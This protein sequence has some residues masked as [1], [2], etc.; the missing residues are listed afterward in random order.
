MAKVTRFWTPLL[1]LVIILFVLSCGC[2]VAQDC[3]G[4][5]GGSSFSSA[6]DY[7]GDD[8]SQASA[9]TIAGPDEVTRP[10]NPANPTYYA[11][12][13]GLG[14]YGWEVAGSGTFIDQETGQLTLGAAACGSFTVTVTD[15]CGTTASKTGRAAGDDPN[16][17]AG[18][19]SSSPETF[20]VVHATEVCGS[21]SS[22]YCYLDAFYAGGYYYYV[23]TYSG[24]RRI[25]TRCINGM[26]TNWCYMGVGQYSDTQ[27]ISLVIEHTADCSTACGGITTV[28]TFNNEY[29]EFSFVTYYGVPVDE[30]IA[31]WTCY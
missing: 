1:I 27:A 2:S 24:S 17:T 29:P 12:S 19:W 5:M 8:C 23:T 20:C 16:N 31:V 21:C 15:F 13:G 11:A 3:G 4:G 22:G 6:G 18:V 26:T 9:L 14:P 25:H 28:S 10:T 7:T 30:T